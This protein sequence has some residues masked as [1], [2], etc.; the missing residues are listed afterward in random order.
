MGIPIGRSFD[1]LFGSLC[2]QN[3]YTSEKNF[4][5]CGGI[6]PLYLRLNRLWRSWFVSLSLSLARDVKIS[7][8]S[9]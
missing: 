5:A 7:M 6:C 3:K 8:E 4:L 2:R 1:R 9:A